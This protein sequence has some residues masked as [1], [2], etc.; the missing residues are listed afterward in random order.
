LMLRGWD[1][2]DRFGFEDWHLDVDSAIEP[3]FVLRNAPA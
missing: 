1:V 3:I 2:I